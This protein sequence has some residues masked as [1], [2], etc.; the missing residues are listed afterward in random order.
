MTDLT[1]SALKRLAKLE[2]KTNVG[3]SL[4]ELALGACRFAAAEHATFETEGFH[5]LAPVWPSSTS[6]VVAP[7][8]Q[9]TAAEVVS[10]TLPP[11]TPYLLNDV[12]ALRDCWP[13]RREKTAFVARYHFDNRARFKLENRT[14]C[15]LEWNGKLFFRIY[16]EEKLEKGICVFG[17]GA[18]N[19]YHWLI[20][21]LPNAMFAESLAPEFDDYP[22]L[23]PEEVVNIPNFR[24]TLEL[25]SGDRDVVALKKGMQYRVGQLIVFPPSVTGPCNLFPGM[26]PDPE[27]YLSDVGLV[28]TFRDRILKDLSASKTKAGP[29]RVFLARPEGARGYNQDEILAVAT[30]HGFQPVRLEKLSFAEQVSLMHNA[31]VVIG[32]TGAA[33]A[34]SLFMRKGAKALVWA[35]EKYDGACF[36]S[37]LAHAA[38]VDMYYEFF[39]ADA[40]VS[41][42]DHGFFLTYE[43]DPARFEASLKGLLRTDSSAG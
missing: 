6:E 7:R 18:T 30:R 8:R 13:L 34:N 38:G 3:Q 23:V 17:H 37:N 4:M 26:W 15:S 22:L 24:A 36:F 41:G 2:P 19:W 14:S 1:R 20:E 10:K 21:T 29:S 39:R 11:V 28:R 12:V 9:G 33:F 43:L 16:R 27:D 31:E 35:H 32:P 42:T 5:Q 25:F 40:E